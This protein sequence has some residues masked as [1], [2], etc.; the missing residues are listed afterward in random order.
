MACV[1]VATGS[2]ALILVGWLAVERGEE[3]HAGNR[4][5]L[6]ELLDQVGSA[7]SGRGFFRGQSPTA[8]ASE[9]MDITV[10]ASMFRC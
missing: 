5:S 7:G 8:T 1:G 3:S 4:P 2:V 6:L 10:G 9:F